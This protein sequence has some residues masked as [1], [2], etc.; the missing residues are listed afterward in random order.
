M[1]VVPE[2]NDEVQTMKAGLMEIANIFVV[3]KADRPDADL[4]VRNLRLMSAPA[5][6]KKDIPMPVIKTIAPQKT[7]IVELHEAIMAHINLHQVNDKRFWLLAE[8]TY[9]L[10]QQKR[11]KGISKKEI[12]KQVEPAG[13]GFNLYKFVEEYQVST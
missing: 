4:I 1:V 5:F 13:I 11:M 10:L 7:G 6:H 8:K 2:A 9:F 12:K 3:N